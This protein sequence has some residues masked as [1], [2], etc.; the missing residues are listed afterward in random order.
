VQEEGEEIT[1][2]YGIEWEKAWQEHVKN[3]DT[4]RPNYTPAFDLNRMEDLQIPTIWETDKQFPKV[5]TFCREDFLPEDHEVAPYKFRY[6]GE[7]EDGDFFLC[8]VLL[9]NDTD[10]TYTVEVFER[11]KWIEEDYDM[12]ETIK[13]TPAL[14]LF[15]LPWDAIFF[16]DM[17]YGRDHHQFW[18]FRHDMRIPDEIFPD[19][20]KNI[21]SNSS[22]QA[23]AK[24]EK[25]L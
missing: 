14:I 12:E 5:L 11:E 8:R 9:R 21:Q 13:D 25:E 16:R 2:D 3:F 6:R 17:P 7:D 24:N 10:N 15:D 22:P 1:M 18:S 23:S 19:V 4:P 20:W